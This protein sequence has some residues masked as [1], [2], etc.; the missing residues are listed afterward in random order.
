MVVTIISIRV[1]THTRMFEQ[2]ILA[3]DDTS[4]GLIILMATVTVEVETEED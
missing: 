4:D 2:I 1:A 3:E